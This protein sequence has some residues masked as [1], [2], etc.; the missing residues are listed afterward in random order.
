MKRAWSDTRYCSA[1]VL[2]R[3][4][5]CDAALI[6]RATTP[7]WAVLGL[8]QHRAHEA[9]QNSPSCDRTT[10][11]THDT[12]HQCSTAQAACVPTFHDRRVRTTPD[13]FSGR[14]PAL[15]LKSIKCTAAPNPPRA[16]PTLRDHIRL[17]K[18]LSAFSNQKNLVFSP[19]S[20]EVDTFSGHFQQG[21]M[22]QMAW[23]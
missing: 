10:P 14:S 23:A 3:P 2:A 6:H 7:A 15:S 4:L 19:Q 22:C 17:R 11:S 13:T 9:A 8:R 21:Q 16:M 18:H 1:A 20:G 12:M 5:P